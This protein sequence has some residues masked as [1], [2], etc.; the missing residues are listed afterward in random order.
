MRIIDCVQGTEEWLRARLG[1]PTCSQADRIL[2]PKTLKPSGQREQYRNQLLAEWIL[3]YPIDW[4]ASSAWMERGT[5]LEAEARA[6]YE[7]ETGTDVQQVGFIRHDDIA[8]GGSPDGLIGDDGGVEIKCPAIHTHIGY[9]LAPDTLADEYRGQV[10]TLLALTGRQWWD[11]WAYNPELPPVR[12]R[13]ERDAEYIKAFG[14]AL[15]EFVRSLEE[16]QEKL[17][18]Y[19]RIPPT[20]EA[21]LA[22][23]TEAE[24]AAPE[25]PE[26]EVA[27][28]DRVL[29]AR[30]ADVSGDLGALAEQ[31]GRRT[32]RSA[33]AQGR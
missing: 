33:Q 2:T 15:L 26:P 25:D 10:Q 18:E 20:V 24:K 30:G 22:A 23:E 6:A 16:A 19:K 4:G 3:G 13:V 14:K 12:V 7:L 21:V 8:F 9:M 27:P 29:A 1:I 5:D 32:G 17:R 11:L 31:A 28:W